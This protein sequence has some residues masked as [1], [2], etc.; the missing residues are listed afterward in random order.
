MAG[1]YHA[2]A[3]WPPSASGPRVWRWR[4]EQGIIGGAADAVFAVLGVTL[5][6]LVSNLRRLIRKSKVVTN[7]VSFAL[8]I[9][10][11]LIR[12]G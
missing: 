6:P 11:I 1:Q 2:S 3:P 4:S 5:A 12:G 8:V 9:I 7:H 10:C